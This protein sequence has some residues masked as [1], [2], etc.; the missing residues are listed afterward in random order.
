MNPTT[1]LETALE[2]EA[3][4]WS[5]LTLC[6]HNHVGVGRSHRGCDSP[7]KRPFFPAKAEEAQGAWKEFQT[8]RATPDELRAQFAVHPDLNVGMA[9]GPVSG[10]VAVDVDDDDGDKL[11][12]ELAGGEIPPTMEYTT[13]K[14]RRLLFRLPAGVTVLNHQFR[15]PGTEIEILR[16][17]S[18]GGQVV[19]PPSR[20]P[21]GAV[22]R[23]VPGRG[24]G[25]VEPAD[26]PEWMRAAQ[27]P[28]AADRVRPA[29]GELIGEGGRNN[30]L[31]SLAG[32]LRKHGADEE[33][34]YAA[35]EK[36]NETRF[37]PPLAD[38]EVRTVARSVARYEPD[39]FSGVTFKVPAVDPAP[40]MVAVD[41]TGRKFKW[42]SELA[43]KDKAE[44]W[45]WE[46]YLPKGAIAMLSALWKAGKTTLMSHILTALASSDKFLGQTVRASKVLY[47]SEEGEQHW[48][49]RRDK[50]NIGD[51][52]GIY[53]QP[54]GVKPTP[55]DWRAFI[56]QLANDVKTH[57]FDL[58]IFDTLA[59][60]WPVLEEN[61][62]GAVDAA[63]MPLWDI[64]KAG[65]GVLL[66]HHL[67]KSGGGEYTG[68]RGSGA[69]SAF[70][71]ILIE[72]TRFD[73]AD[74]KSAK[75]VLK[76]KGRYDETPDEIVIELVEDRYRRIDGDLTPESTGGAT[77]TGGGVTMRVPEPKSDE[78]RVL[79]VLN[80]ELN[81]LWMKIDDIA[82]KMRNRG[83]SITDAN[84][85]PILFAFCEPA[86]KD[87]EPLVKQKGKPRSPVNPVVYA[88]VARL[89]RDAEESHSS[90]STPGCVATNDSPNDYQASHSVESF[91]PET[92]GANESNDLPDWWPEL[93]FIIKVNG[94]MTADRLHEISGY[95]ADGIVSAIGHYKAAGQLTEDDDGICHLLE[96]QQ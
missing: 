67:R 11:L 42:F 12:Y 28:A 64:T 21:N 68:S 85:K 57:G 91:A 52:V 69:L 83:W 87:A 80:D 73:A 89:K 72:L 65:A 16:F 13:G 60:L 41:A 55:A 44:E 62:A 79:A 37:D 78:D 96:A 10:L 5:V 3:L 71:D 50:L 29:D 26:V 34:I 36:V 39:P 53:L 45:I 54:F 4:G 27:V 30:Y 19:L 23:W 25:E 48:V 82:A 94:P 35:L 66:I 47:V 17:M 14:G 33:V 15:R 77:Q 74:S 49:R 58:V 20:H 8:R 90:R 1:R 75:R 76:A 61:D 38:A 51:H 46:G 88:S 59:K 81:P 31:T 9:L 92:Q 32:V 6:P 63:L 24:P 2:Y 95:P 18:A 86:K 7:G 56:T 93:L 22:Y 40:S 43:A 84:V 70:A